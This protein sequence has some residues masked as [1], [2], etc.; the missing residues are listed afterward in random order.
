[1]DKF[2]WKTC[3]NH[4]YN[5]NSCKIGVSTPL[6]SVSM[7]ENGKTHSCVCQMI[8]LSTLHRG[9][10]GGGCFFLF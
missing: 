9:G 2:C 3:K 6:H 10:V 8:F 4:D 1:M 5:R 7:F